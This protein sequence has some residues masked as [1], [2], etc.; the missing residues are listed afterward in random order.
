MSRS[1]SLQGTAFGADLGKAGGQHQHAF[2][3][4]GNAVPDGHFHAGHRREDDGL[5]HRAGD[6]GDAGKSRQALDF[7]SA[8]AVDRVQP[9][10]K[11]GLDQEAQHPAADAVGVRGGADDSHRGGREERAEGVS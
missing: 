10:L 1:R 11:A 2:D 3:A 4:L 8:A 9:A 6:I 5:V 7:G